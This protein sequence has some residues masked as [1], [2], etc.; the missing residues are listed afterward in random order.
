[1]NVVIYIRI[2]KQTQFCE[3]KIVDSALQK[4]RISSEFDIDFEKKQFRVWP[5]DIDFFLC[6]KLRI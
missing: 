4:I 1:M 6:R 5:D 3:K 2:N